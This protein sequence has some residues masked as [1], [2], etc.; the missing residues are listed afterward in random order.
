MTKEI[1]ILGLL[2]EFQYHL[3]AHHYRLFLE[4]WYHGKNI[5]LR[6]PGAFIDGMH[7]VSMQPAPQ[8]KFI[9]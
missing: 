3:S 1:S 4:S 9:V 6:W 7:E 5:R 2:F 8:L